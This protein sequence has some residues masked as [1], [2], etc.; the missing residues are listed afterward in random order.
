MFERATNNTLIQAQ[1]RAHVL[2]FEA[3]GARLRGATALTISQCGI[4]SVRIVKVSL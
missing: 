2:P 4:A 3:A 1:L